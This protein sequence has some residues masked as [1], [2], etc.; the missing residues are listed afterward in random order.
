MR[1]AFVPFQKYA[2]FSG[3]ARRAEYLQYGLLTGILGVALLL[4]E[5]SLGWNSGETGYG[6]MTGLFA[7]ATL[8]PNLAVSV[9]R[10][11]DCGYSGWFLLVAF[12]PIINLW[13]L[14]VLTF[15]DSQFGPNNHGESPKAA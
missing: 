10:L 2:T 11:H 7:L 9:R 15:V 1:Y 5:L 4:I 3:R 14:I 6:P 13:P 12:I 8:L